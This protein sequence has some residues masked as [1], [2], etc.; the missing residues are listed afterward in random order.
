MR[1]L[2][3]E[4]TAEEHQ[5]ISRAISTDA[6]LALQYRELVL[7]KGQMDEAAMTPSDAVV[8]RILNYARSVSVKEV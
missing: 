4:T 7:L 1:F 3:Q 6:D 8:S 2:Y 5:E